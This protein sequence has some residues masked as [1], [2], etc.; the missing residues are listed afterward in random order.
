MAL[1]LTQSKPKPSKFC[2]LCNF[3]K[4]DINTTTERAR[5]ILLRKKAPYVS[6]E[7]YTFPDTKACQDALH[8]VKQHSP[9]FLVNHSIRS[10][11]FG[12]AMSHKVQKKID[13]EVF[14]IGSIMHDIGLTDLAPQQDTF[15]IE[16]ASIARDFSISHNLTSNQADL[17]HEMVALHNSVGVA[18]K[19][20]PEVALLHYGAGADVAGLWVHDIHKNTLHE[21]LD[22]YHDKGCKEGM[23]HLIKDQVLRKPES[24][25]S[26]MVELG[27]LKKM[28]KNNLI[29]SA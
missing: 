19:H 9:N 29:K 13:K 16:G 3:I 18:H 28:A 22:L 23:M 7:Y 14:F 8:L 20:D 15:E 24:Y 4:S 5:N 2:M 10:Y 17:I 11:A 21:I 1:T 26:T 12:L 6:P 25:M 27:F